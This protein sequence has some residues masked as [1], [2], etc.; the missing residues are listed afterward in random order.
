MRN[1]F[2]N[3]STDFS[4]ENLRKD[5][6]LFSKFQIPNQLTFSNQ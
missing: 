4:G 5:D 2:D 1:L 3:T 6:Y